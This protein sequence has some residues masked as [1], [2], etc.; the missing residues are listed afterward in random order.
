MWSPESSF[1]RLCRGAAALAIAVLTAG[2]FQ[3]LYGERT[4]GGGP[5]LRDQLAAVDVLQIPAPK[6]TDDDRLAVEI[7]NALLF[8][9]TGGHGEAAPIHRLKMSMST[10]RTAMIVDKNTGRSDVEDYGI[11]VTYSLTEIATG[12]I[13]VTGQTFSR[14]SYDI[15]GQQQRYARLR[16]LRDA[17]SRAAKVIAENIRS[18]LSSYFIAG[19]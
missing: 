15:P 2:C 10:T 3:P 6:G 19:A 5:I 13:V 1:S 9:L 7:R 14:V 16:G 4:V 18:R 12:R 17:E 8:D 11:T